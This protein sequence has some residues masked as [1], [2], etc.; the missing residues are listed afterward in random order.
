M[1]PGRLVASPTKGGFK[2][3]GGDDVELPE[4]KQNRLSCY[5]YRTPGYYFLTFCT[6]NRENLFWRHTNSENPI[7]SRDGLIVDQ[8]IQNIPKIYPMVHLDKYVIMPNHV[9]LILYLEGCK[10]NPNGPSISTIVGQ[11]K[12]AASRILGKDIW[13]RSFHD[14][15]IRNEKKYQKIWLYIEDNPRRWKE[16]CFYHE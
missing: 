5:D 10:E 12:Q 3:N 13:Q 4:R 2:I 9:H 1:S 6:R 14:H 16:D 15:V 11:M 8:C 7:L